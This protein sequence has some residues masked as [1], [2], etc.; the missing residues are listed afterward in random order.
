MKNCINLQISCPNF[1]LQWEKLS[2]N[3]KS[4]DKKTSILSGLDFPNS[5]LYEMAFNVQILEKLSHSLGGSY[6]T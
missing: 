3:N 6:L 4:Y 1:I 5:E 2:M